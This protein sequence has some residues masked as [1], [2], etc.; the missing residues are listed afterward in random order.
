MIRSLYTAATGMQAQQTNMDVVANNLANV[1]TAGFKKSRAEFQDLLYQTLRSPGAAQAQG[2]QVP[3]GV[4][5]GLGTRLVATQKQFTA[6]DMQQTGNDLDMAV[7]GDGFFRVKLP[8]GETGYTRSGAF[9]KDRDGKMVT[10]DGYILQPEITIPA[11]AQT[12]NIGE[13]GTV[14][15]TVAGQAAPQVLDTV[16]LARF[17]NP[18]GLNS[19]GGNIYLETDASGQAI[20][21]TPSQDG[22][23]GILNKFLEMSNVK[24]VDEMVNMILAQRAYEINSKSIQAADEM[25][26]AANSLRR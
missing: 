17:I 25:L 13:D 22:F 9:T 7:K 1:N 26:Q 15:V 3:T 18:A 20:E 23:G 2:A 19:M 12:I 10:A 11:E 21:G 16:T 6:G 14:S 4:Q 5:V 24:V 8:T